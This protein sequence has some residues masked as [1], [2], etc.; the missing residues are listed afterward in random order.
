[1]SI[2]MGFAIA[3]GSFLVGVLVGVICKGFGIDEAVEQMQEKCK[4]CKDE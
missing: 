1:M 3:F 2:A 4:R